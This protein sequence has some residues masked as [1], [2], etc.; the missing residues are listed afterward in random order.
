[1]YSYTVI[2]S[3]QYRTLNQQYTKDYVKRKQHLS[4]KK[5][6]EISISWFDSLALELAGSPGFPE[7]DSAAHPASYLSQ[8]TSFLLLLLCA[9]G[10]LEDNSIFRFGEFIKQLYQVLFLCQFL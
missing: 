7:E 9:F 8:S 5:T 6:L 2:H 4:N 3:L 10:S 1:M